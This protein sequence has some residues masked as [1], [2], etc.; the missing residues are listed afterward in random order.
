M[1]ERA[2]PIVALLALAVVATG[3]MLGF[4]ATGGSGDPL[5]GPRT[6]VV[7]VVRHE[8]GP[9]V[10]V[11]ASGGGRR[12]SVVTI[13]SALALTV[14]GQGDARAGDAALLPGRPAATAF[15]NLLGA[16]I[17][18]HAV[19]DAQALS[20]VIDRLGGLQVFA[21]R[22]DGAGVVDALAAPG[23][24]VT[25]GEVVRSLISSGPDWRQEDFVDV[26]DPAAVQRALAPA[27]PL[28]STLPTAKVLGG[29]AVVDDLAAAELSARVFGVEPVVPVPV[30]VLNGSGEPGVGAAV[31]EH[32]IR[33]G[34]RVV[35]SGNAADFNHRETLVV[36]SSPE[37]RD[38]AEGAQAALGVGTVS[39]S[40]APTGVGDVT[41]VV[42]KDFE[43]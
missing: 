36:A 20:E 12:S 13:P 34:F 27:D 28:V 21:D 38:A 42:G 4:E 10:A 8:A 15:S 5:S 3:L 22:L 11:V 6:A 26:D 31:A 41:I 30:V 1:T 33:A 7:L 14:P 19:V 9:L 39:V 32:L 35:L 2:G 17:S 16:W 29:L 37:D 18:H 23:R 43:G 24:F 25:W 40:G